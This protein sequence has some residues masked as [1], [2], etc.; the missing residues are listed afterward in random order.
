MT[1]ATGRRSCSFCLASL[2]LSAWLLT[3]SATIQSGLGN[4]YIEPSSKVPDF[5][6]AAW[7][8]AFKLTLRSVPAAYSSGEVLHS[9]SF[10]NTMLSSSQVAGQCS[11]QGFDRVSAADVALVSASNGRVYGP[12]SKACF[13]GKFVP[14]R[15]Q[16]QHPCIPSLHSSVRHRTATLLPKV[17]VAHMLISSASVSAWSA[18][19]LLQSPRPCWH[20]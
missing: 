16:M 1:P 19:L 20:H 18:G 15:C 10:P 7:N 13:G 11:V 12:I 3:A 6:P 2:M 4:N 8:Q 14:H 5:D 17:M 9:L